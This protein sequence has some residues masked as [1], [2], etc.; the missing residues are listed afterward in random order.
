MQ[1][2]FQ[3]DPKKISKQEILHKHSAFKI[4]LSKWAKSGCINHQ[5]YS[6]HV[7]ARILQMFSIC[8]FTANGTN[9]QGIVGCTPTN[10]PLWEIPI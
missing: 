1:I 3:H 7:D 8:F 5:G 4:C 2:L 9:L 6:V 10:V